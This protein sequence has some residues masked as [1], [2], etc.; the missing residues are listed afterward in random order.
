MYKRQFLVIEQGEV[1]SVYGYWVQDDDTGEEGFLPEF[2]DV[3][4]TYDDKNDVW[5]SSFFH[6]R[7]LRNK[8]KGK[9]NPTKEKE[10]QVQRIPCSTLD[11]ES[12]G[13]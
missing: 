5:A 4:W 8:G 10:R 1:E 13:P 7:M 9:V 6:G 12:S 11:G 3:L 2:D